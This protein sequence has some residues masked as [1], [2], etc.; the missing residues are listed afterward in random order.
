MDA[1]DPLRTAGAVAVLATSPDT[2]ITPT[3]TAWG[4]DVPPNPE[5]EPYTYEIDVWR[6]ATA[7][8]KE[9]IAQGA[10]LVKQSVLRSPSI[11]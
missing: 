6:T 5:N 3:L 2:Q 10:F 11:P 7:G 1:A 4:M 8:D 9:Q